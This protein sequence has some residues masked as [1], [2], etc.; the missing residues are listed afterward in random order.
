MTGTRIFAIAVSTAVLSAASLYAGDLSKYREF[1]LGMNLAALAKQAQMKPSDAK[2]IHQRP[3]LIQELE[4]QPRFAIRSGSDSDTD[5]VEEVLFSLYNN[6]LSRMVVSYNRARTEGLTTED[7][8][9]AISATYGAAE[10]PEAEIV[11]PSVY[12]ETVKV[13]AR[14]EDSQYSLSLVRLAPSSYQPEFGMVLLSKRLD[15]LAQA[16][17]AAAIRL[18]EQEAPQREIERQKKVEDENRAEQEKAR[19]ANKANFRP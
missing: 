1:Q 19:P 8:I 12:R 11:F 3:A 10:K 9:E 17:S 2:T 5:S 7:M 13:V 16:A 18:D 15:A 4:W 14:W 6:Q